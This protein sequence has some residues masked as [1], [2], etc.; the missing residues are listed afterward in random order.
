MSEISGILGAVNGIHTVRN[1]K[2]S[3]NASLQG[4]VASNTKNMRAVVDG[5]KDWNGSFAAY[6]HTPSV[7]PGEA[8]AFV[9]SIDGA[10]GV[11]GNAIIDS[12]EVAI[13][14]EG[15]APIANAVT[16][17]GNGA[18]ALGVAAVAADTTTPAIFPS[19]GRKVEIA[20]PASPTPSYAEL[21]NVRTVTLRF[22]AANTS[23]ADS[24]TA[25][26]VKRF[27]GPLSG[28]ISMSVHGTAVELSNLNLILPNTDKFVKIYVT[29][30]EYWLLQVIKFES[31]S[32]VVVDR[33]T[34]AIVGASIGGQFS[35]FYD[36]S[37]TLTEG[38]V[39]QPGEV[40]WWPGA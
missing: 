22:A 31:I 21:A 25:G 39:E 23:Y 6:G 20:T 5:N 4:G 26:L 35:G 32:D 8:I 28:S 10:K 16:F 36:L 9:G 13:D 7:M 38:I 3:T 29:A 17:S 15:G 2:V 1:W 24:A 19:V 33:E 14:I 30:T 27:K 34:G 12:V 18:I 40:E 37:G 11:T